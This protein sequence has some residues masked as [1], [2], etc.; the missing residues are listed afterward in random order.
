MWVLFLTTE[1]CGERWWGCEV[2]ARGRGQHRADPA[3]KPP[4]LPPIITK[5]RIT[6]LVSIFAF[7][8]LHGTLTASWVVQGRRCAN[9]LPFEWLA[10][11]ESLPQPLLEAYI[12]ASLSVPPSPGKS[13]AL[14][15]VV[16]TWT[17]A[18]PL[19]SHF[20]S[21]GMSGVLDTK[22]LGISEKAPHF[23]GTCT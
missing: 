22:P 21:P 13:E 2:A 8:L 11:L 17:R 3:L 15:W 5:R 12:T 14:K 20:T 16:G 19:N 7:F 9:C 23:K 18:G 1:V 6:D 10:G 4:L